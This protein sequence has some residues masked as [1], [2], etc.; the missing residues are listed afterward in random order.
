MTKLQQ[1]RLG[2]AVC[3]SLALPAIAGA[4]AA[5]TKW[6]LAE[7][8]AGYFDEEILAINPTGTP[9]VGVVH[10]LRNG[11]APIDLPFTVPATRRM[12]VNVKQLAVANGLPANF[13]DVSAAIEVTN[14]VPIFVERTMYWNNRDAG[15]NAPALQ[16]P[17]NT[18]YL[19]EGAANSF[20]ECFILLANPNAA[21]ASATVTLQKDD[22]TVLNY[23]V[24][25]PA[26]QRVTVY[27]NDLP[28]F[29]AGSFAT[30]VNADQPIFVER[31][32]YWQ[33]HRGGHDATAVPTLSNTWRFAEGFTGSGFE[34]FFLLSNPGVANVDATLRFLLDTGAVVDKVVTIPAHARTTV[35]VNDYAE[36]Q[37]A[38]FGTVISAAS[39]IVAERAA[40]WGG[41]KEGSATA[42]LT[43]EANSFAF[44]EG[45]AGTVN[46]ANYETYYLFANS[47][48]SP[49]DVTGTF[50]REDGFGSVI[51][52]QIPAH[53][54][55]TLF[56]GNVPDMNNQRFGA[57]FQAA[58]NATFI[59]E[60]AQ[61]WN[62]RN[63]GTAS[64]GTPWGDTIVA[65]PP[66]PVLPPTP[67]PPP[68]PPP[69]SC[70]AVLCD[71]LQGGTSGN[72]M[73]GTFDSFGFVATGENAGIRWE[74]PAIQS[75]YFQAEVT[76]IRQQGD[77]GN[78]KPKIM[79]MFDT[80]WDSN[81]PFRATAEKRDSN[82]GNAV[83]FKFLS[84]MSTVGYLELDTP[85]GW[86][87][88]EVYTF[89]MEWRPGFAH[90]LILRSDG[91]VFSDV[92]GPV[93]GVYNPAHHIIQI[94]NPNAGDHA[95]YVGMRV[96]NV[97]VGRN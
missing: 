94:G 6:Y 40:Y 69:P 37:N 26:N 8:N 53:A 88:N 50:Y 82:K 7:G 80:S 77:A 13:G 24:A 72:L 93:P 46:G 66:V 58:N 35:R 91:S 90:L 55:Y 64:T 2:L 29:G 57:I 36:M 95:T 17:S 4:Q 60:R 76:G 59:A 9:A 1:L 22:G 32:M 83:R 51:T 14:G 84:G 5:H 47:S 96:R 44:A 85:G 61:Y 12:T 31:S 30:T 33:G 71:S 28:G 49:V 20:F 21:P 56:G 27:V 75:G 19:A 25:V 34:T 63:G 16:S 43:A 54:R 86:N 78:E 68:P 62:N 65:P 87:P 79:A 73:G 23:P 41:F 11:A 3:L 38:A 42:G 18:W 45:A 39:G 70:D 74:V 10:V 92:G 81:N 48:D 89:R 97:K 67:P 15:T 52:F